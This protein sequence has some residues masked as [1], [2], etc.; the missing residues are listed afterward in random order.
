M[1]SHE[2]LAD[3]QNMYNNWEVPV[4]ASMHAQAD[5]GAQY[6]AECLQDAYE[7]PKQVFADQNELITVAML[8]GE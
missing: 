3:I 2:V 7:P 4:S 6:A 1:A 5:E 8:I